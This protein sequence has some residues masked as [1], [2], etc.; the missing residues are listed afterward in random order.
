MKRGVKKDQIP[1]SVVV[2]QMGEMRQD[3]ITGKWV[4]V[5]PGRTKRPHDVVQERSLPTLPRFKKNCP[6]C[7]LDKFPQEP[8]SVRLP[9]DP[10]HWQVHIFPN[11]YPAFFPAD[12]FR[13]WH[14]GPYRVAEA[15][16]Y[17]D[18]LATRWHD[19]IDGRLTQQQWLWQL[20]ALVL[21]Y[22]QLR[23]KPSVNY[24]QIIKNYRPE[25]GQSLEHPH[26]Q[27]FTV[28]VL[29]AKIAQLLQGAERYAKQHGQDGFSVMLEYER[30]SGERTIGENDHFT[31]FCPFA[32]EVPFQICIMPRQPNPFF[33]NIG[34][35]ERQA[36]AQM[37]QHVMGRLYLGLK[38]PPYNYYI[39]SAPCDE[40]GFVCSRE[41]FEHFRWHI[42]IVPRLSPQGGFEI[43]TGLDI[44]TTWPEASA[45]FLRELPFDTYTKNF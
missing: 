17:H 38:D 45:V 25:A 12:D 10:Q 41:Q 9:D 31:A 29:P 21:R 40:T 37:M 43:G 7:E 20:E 2:G 32:S 18:L 24:I 44:N 33:E 15:V 5:A 34:P 3:I 1:G 4:V 39:H 26:H 27:I 35:Q 11:K 28:P 36:L 8:D 13:S 30:Q 23:S 14:K 42:D 19:E 6:F 16:G 22:R